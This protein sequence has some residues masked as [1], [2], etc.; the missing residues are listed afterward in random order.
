MPR[1]TCC[2]CAARRFVA[3]PFDP[4][5]LALSGEPTPIAEGIGA[6]AVAGGD[7]FGVFSASAGGVLA[8]QTSASV[9]VHQLAWF[10]RSGRQV[11]S[12][13]EPAS[14]QSIE[15]L[16][17]DQRAAMSVVDPTR[18]TRD[19]WIFDIP[20][21]VR[22]RFTFDPT[23][24]RSAIGSPDGRFIAF[25]SNRTG[26][27]EIYRKL[28]S[29]AGDEELMFGDGRS[30]DPLS[31]SPDGRFLVF[32]VTTETS[33]N[34]IMALPLMEEGKP[35]P[36]VATPFDENYAKVSPDG[37]WLAYTSDESGRFEVYVT[38]FPAASGKWQVST[39]GGSFPRWRG[40]GRELYYLAPGN[41]LTAV[42]VA[43]TASAFTVEQPQA[44]FKTNLPNQ[45]GYPYAV[46]RDGQRFLVNT[47]LAVPN[48]L[49]VIVN[50]TSVLK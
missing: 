26:A 6:G 1:A 28:A 39:D 31:W 48:P 9:A 47:N 27:L 2:T 10:D 4:D 5:R 38:S 34:D 30:K 49:T 15:I 50:W 7:R 32:R 42:T 19:I 46:M 24:E 35:I 22:T 8:Y 36:L 12:L 44:L 23:E 25:N 14:H 21:G 20:R 43:G 33:S 41:V 37:R 45:P 29:G 3:Q 16:P 17:D 18:R 13:G 40:D 11:A